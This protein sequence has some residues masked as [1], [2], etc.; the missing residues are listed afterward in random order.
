[1]EGCREPLRRH[2]YGLWEIA[3]PPLSLGKN[4]Q[5]LTISMHPVLLKFQDLC[6]IHKLFN[7][8]GASDF[9]F[10]MFFLPTD[11]LMEHIQEIR[12]LR[13][14]LEES[15]KTNEKLRKQL[16]RQGSEAEQGKEE[17]SQGKECGWVGRCCVM[18]A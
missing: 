11:L 7:L 17:L 6:I 5:L 13:N 18:F 10:K 2:G 14:R 15:I 16:E 12:T 9:K 1:M 8:L 4:C 3:W